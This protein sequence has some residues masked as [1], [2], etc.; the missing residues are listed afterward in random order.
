M[1][2]TVHC[3]YVNIWNHKASMSG[4]DELRDSRHV[5]TLPDIKNQQKNK[6]LQ[7]IEILRKWLILGHNWWH[8]WRPHKGYHYWVLLD[9]Q[10]KFLCSA[11]DCCWEINHLNILHRVSNGKYCLTHLSITIANFSRF[12]DNYR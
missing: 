3:R 11:I 10:P 8:C 6:N 7:E 5:C 2:Q 12:I 4:R 9:H 1:I